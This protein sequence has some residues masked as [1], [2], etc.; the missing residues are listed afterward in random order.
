MEV[1]TGSE[2][3]LDCVVHERVLCMRLKAPLIL[4]AVKRITVHNEKVVTAPGRRFPSGREGRKVNADILED[5]N[6]D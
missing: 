4:H 6:S 3:A 1:P 5:E 2:L